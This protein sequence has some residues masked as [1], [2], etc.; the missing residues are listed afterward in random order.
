MHSWKVGLINLKMYIFT[1]YN[2][3]PT[4]GN[5]YYLFRV[6]ILALISS[7]FIL[8]KRLYNL[9]SQV[10]LPLNLWTLAL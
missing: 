9:L 4:G 7:I 5:E 8:L 6:N 3:N 2:D 10:L 1:K